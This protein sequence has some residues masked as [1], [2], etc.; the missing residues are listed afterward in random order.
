MTIVV[1]RREGILIIHMV[2]WR[3]A[4]LFFYH[5][6]RWL[7]IFHCSGSVFYSFPGCPSY[8]AD[9]TSLEVAYDSIDSDAF[10][11]AFDGISYRRT[12]TRF[13]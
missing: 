3:V 2:L 5:T 9:L 8:G 6:M 13:R 10:D 7:R 11:D 1:A 4:A 12:L